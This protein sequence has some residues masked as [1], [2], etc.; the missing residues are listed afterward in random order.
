MGEDTILNFSLIAEVERRLRADLLKFTKDTDPLKEVQWI[1]EYKGMRISARASPNATKNENS[2]AENFLD[3]EFHISN[4]HVRDSKS[5]LARI[6]FDI[7]SKFENLYDE[8]E[9]DFSTASIDDR[10]TLA[11]IPWKEI[12]PLI[13]LYLER[14]Q[15]SHKTKKFLKNLLVE[16]GSSDLLSDEWNVGLFQPKEG[17]IQDEFTLSELGFKTPKENLIKVP[18][19]ASKID[20]KPGQTSRELPLLCIYLENPN[21]TQSGIPIYDNN[22]QPIVMLSFYL[23]EKALSPTFV[24]WARPGAQDKNESSEE[25]E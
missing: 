8:F 22:G 5:E 4:L 14:Y 9:D 17:D 13:K 21:Q 24:E 18:K 10:F 11:S 7:Y 23:P 1:R 20:Y 15:K 6:Q 19:Q 16:I 12:E 25:E 2:S 3:P